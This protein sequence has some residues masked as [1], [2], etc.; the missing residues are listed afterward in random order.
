MDHVNQSVDERLDRYLAAIAS[1]HVAAAREASSG[2]DPA[3]IK[4][5][6]VQLRRARCVLEQ[7]ATT[8]PRRALLKEM[9]WLG[10][11]AGAVRDL[12]VWIKRLRKLSPK[13][14]RAVDGVALERLVDDFVQRRE[15]E[16]LRLSEGLSGARAQAIWSV[17]EAGLAAPAGDVEIAR[18]LHVGADEARDALHF[19]AQALN[20]DSTDE[21]VHS[22]RLHAK[23]ARYLLDA[24]PAQWRRGDGKQLRAVQRQLGRLHDAEVQLGLMADAPHPPEVVTVVVAA[25]TRRRDKARSRGLRALESLLLQSGSV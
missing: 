3:S 20:A 14:H 13:L 18:R 19:G 24:V 22:L 7:V 5:L 11:Q 10:R 25:L 21:E 15:A 2:A 9:R 6:R 8:A 1:V 17:A 4:R 12:D 16:R 23:R